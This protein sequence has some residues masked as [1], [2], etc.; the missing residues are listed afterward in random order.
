VNRYLVRELKGLR[1]WTEEVRNKIKLA[2]GSI[3]GI[4]EIPAEIHAIYRIVREI[5]M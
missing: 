1:L 5:P 2:E 4:T 3:Q